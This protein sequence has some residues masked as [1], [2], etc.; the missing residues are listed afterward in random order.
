MPKMN[1]EPN[2]FK[3]MTFSIKHSSNFFN[4]YIVPKAQAESKEISREYR[5]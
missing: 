2:F 1:T 5:F 3:T 4:T